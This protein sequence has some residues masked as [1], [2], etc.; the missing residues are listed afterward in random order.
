MLHPA[1]DI[2]KKVVEKTGTPVMI[3]DEE[4]IRTRISEYLDNFKSDKFETR[5]LYA[6]KAFCSGYTARMANEAG[7]YFDCVSGG[8]VYC[9][10]TNGVPVS[11]LYFHGNN[12]TPREIT[13]YLGKGR[14]HIVVDN[15][16]ELGLIAKIAEE[17]GK[18]ADILVRVNPGVEAHTHEYIA[19]ATKDSK[20]GI[21]I[22]KKDEILEMVE[23]VNASSQLEFQGFHAHIGSQIFAASSFEG[24][25]QAMFDFIEEMVKAHGVTVNE[26]DL[27][28]G[29]AI[30]YTDAD[31][32][33]DIPTVCKRMITNCECQMET[34]GLD[35]KIICIE[36]GRSL[37][38][39]SGYT[40]YT[41]GCRKK[42]DS[43]EY[44]FI[45][46]GMADNIRPALYDAEYQCTNL[47]RETEPA[48]KNYVIAGKCC[49]S[50]D[51]IIKEAP[52]P[53]SYPG[54]LILVYSTGAYGYSMASVY[55]KLGRPPVVFVNGDSA[56]V[57]L[58]R[59]DYKELEALETNE[60]IF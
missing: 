60:S 4:R 11:K 20:F 45:D 22:D 52:L 6:S 23:T 16:D 26:L 53:E 49:E 57:V 39:D 34:R 54:D 59:E 28:G 43:K 48:T 17:E 7:M 19:T 18:P 44:L 25:I 1:T 9:L 40:I 21:S 14:G 55:N 10:T 3:Y 41:A 24:E 5:V 31:D 8:E 13:E 36:P 35:I 12:K 29:F 33:D 51:V 46:G 15:A 58:K 42:T 56:K 27:G 38:G 30:Q 50:G 2:L 37:V 32:P 47:T